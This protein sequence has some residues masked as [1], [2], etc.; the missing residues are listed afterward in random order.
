LSLPI[1]I[2]S[3]HILDVYDESGMC[4]QGVHQAWYTTR[5]QQQAGCGPA[6]CAQIMWYL[7]QTK[8]SLNTLVP[9]DCS[10]KSQMLSF[11]KDIWA[12]VT[13]GRMGVNRLSTFTNGALAYAQSSGLT[14]AQHTLSIP[15]RSS[16]RPDAG[17]MITFIAQALKADLPVAFLN[18][19]N[20]ALHNLDNWHWV[21]LIAIDP[22]SGCA[23][24]IDQGRKALLDLPLWLRTTRIGGGFVVLAPESALID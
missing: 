23:Q 10:Q 11:M 24:M 13:P 22:A 3:P 17:A 16:D 4:S 12:F 7:S 18:L 1:A 14:L 9:Y 19:S 15:T 21:T 8:P 5:W 2:R 6:N 20:G